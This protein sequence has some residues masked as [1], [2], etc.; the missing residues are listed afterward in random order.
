M[1]VSTVCGSVVHVFILHEIP[2][3][4]VNCVCVCVW[5]IGADTIGCEILKNW[6]MM[7]IS[8]GSDGKICVADMDIIR[9]YSVNRQFLF[10][11]WDVKVRVLTLFCCKYFGTIM[12]IRSKLL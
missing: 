7:G 9:R 1:T 6:A 12:G 2:A 5:K 3:A 4:C 10:R 11:P 8:V